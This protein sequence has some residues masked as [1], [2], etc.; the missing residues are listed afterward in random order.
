MLVG[1]DQEQ[2]W[3]AIPVEAVD[4]TAAGDAFN[5]GFA[6]ALAR[7][8]SEEKAGAYATAAAACSVKRAGAQPSM[9]DHDEVEAL[10]R[11]NAVGQG[12]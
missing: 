5:A 4:T 2:F 6:A 8:L 10:L 9:P 11:G 3:P 12:A 7:G 1:S